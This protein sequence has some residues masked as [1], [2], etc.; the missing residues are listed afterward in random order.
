MFIFEANLFRFRCLANGAT[1]I[2]LALVKPALILRIRLDMCRSA[3]GMIE[4]QLVHETRVGLT[5][6]PTLANLV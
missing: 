2:K 6:T 5:N 3:H 4:V 1:E